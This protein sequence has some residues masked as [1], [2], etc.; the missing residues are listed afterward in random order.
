MTAL[1]ALNGSPASSSDIEIAFWL[2]LT[3]PLS[4]LFVAS[5]SEIYRSYCFLIRSIYSN[6]TS[7]NFTRRVTHSVMIYV[8]KYHL[9]IYRITY[10]M[11]EE[12][13]RPEFFAGQ[14]E[15]RFS[16]VSDFL[17]PTTTY[18]RQTSDHIFFYNTRSNE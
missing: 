10:C 2:W 15:V 4:L 17:S 16:I 1:I 7:G 5:K 14:L 3:L 6:S 18:V 11:A 8:Y 9:I 13:T 12:T